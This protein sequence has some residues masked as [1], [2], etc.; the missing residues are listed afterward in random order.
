MTL[1]NRQKDTRRD[2]FKHG[3]TMGY[4][5][6]N[7]PGDFIE[8]TAVAIYKGV[9]CGMYHDGMARAGVLISGEFKDPLAYDP[10]NGMILIN[11]HKVVKDLKIH[12][13]TYIQSLRDPNNEEKRRNFERR[14][15]L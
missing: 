3:F 14:F 13:Y 4:G 9:R 11:P 12:F 6:N 1:A 7:Y 8:K 10:N 2:F 15:G 5:H